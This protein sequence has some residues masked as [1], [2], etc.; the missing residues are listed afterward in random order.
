M[1]A[2]ENSF[3]PNFCFNRARTVFNVTIDITKPLYD[4]RIY[5]VLSIPK[6][7]EDKNY[8]LKIIQTTFNVC[9]VM[10][11]IAG[12]FIAKII[13]DMLSKISNVD[14]KFLKCPTVTG[15]VEV[16]N[17][18]IND[19]FIPT[20]LLKNNQTGLVSGKMIGK[21]ESKKF[22]LLAV[23]AFARVEN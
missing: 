13:K 2:N 1:T 18:S 9:K 6:D 17:V 10:N 5:V 23:K 12:D 20:F 4:I 21:I 11:G 16:T 7:H 8:K 3:K 15:R 19:Y 14:K 22:E